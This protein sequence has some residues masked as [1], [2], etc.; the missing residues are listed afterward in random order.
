MQCV[1]LWP[2]A[3]LS[4]L[5]AAQEMCYIQTKRGSQS[6]ST[7]MKC[8]VLLVPTLALQSSSPLFNDPLASVF[9]FLNHSLPMI[10]TVI[11]AQM[12][13]HASF[14]LLKSIF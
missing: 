4:L 8:V 3:E 7:F 9:I 12:D 1:S 5:E 14:K 13:V 2:K 6:R 10:I 11:C